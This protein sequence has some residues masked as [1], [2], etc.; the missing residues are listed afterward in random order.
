MVEKVST[1]AH[2]SHAHGDLVDRVV[3][4]VRPMFLNQTR[5]SVLVEDAS[6]SLGVVVIRHLEICLNL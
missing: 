3:D 5:A 1:Q 2:A 4:R 6:P